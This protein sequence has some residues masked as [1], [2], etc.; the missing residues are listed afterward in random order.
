[1]KKAITILA[2]LAVIGVTFGSV[3]ARGIAPTS[4]TKSACSHGL[5]PGNISYMFWGAKVEDIEQT[6]SIAAAQKD[7]PGL[8]IK[9]IWDTGNYD[10]DLTTEL[11]SGNAPDVFQLDP[12]KRIKEF[13]TEGAALNLAPY[14]K[15]DHFNPKATYWKQC[16]VQAYYKG[17]GPY[18]LVRDCGN[19]SMV[20][21]NKNLFQARHVKFPTNSMTL[22]QFRADAV[23]LSGT[24]NYNGVSELRF[25]IG[26]QTDE[27]HINGYMFSF[28]GAWLTGSGKCGLT[29]KGSREG[30]QW[31]YNL[32]NKYHGA[33]TAGQATGPLGDFIGGF[34]HE[35][36]AMA[37]VG[38]W[39]LGYGV[40]PP[41]VT[42]NKPVSFKW[43]IALPAAGPLGH[44]GGMVDPALET[45]WSGSK[46]KH[47]AYEFTRFLTTSRPA[48]LEGADGIGIPGALKIAKSK[49]VQKE[50][51]P[52]YKTWTA[53]INDGLPLRTVAKHT[54]FTNAVLGDLGNFWNGSQSLNQATAKA[55]ADSKPY[56]G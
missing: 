30:L 1:M 12:G 19:A 8:H 37:L 52:Y 25:G 22:S 50:Y 2:A 46:H 5:V 49:V 21:F 7:C 10:V 45:V 28:G 16:I 27:Y 48:S 11:G 17:K 33:P 29:Q 20:I 53:G 13:V 3:Y 51:A 15:K 39:I 18:G 14:V 38:P 42:G 24:Y 55:C 34:E 32:A 31:W 56:L 43:G 23:K 44:N 26:I 41:A 40:K 35:R 47:A 4:V 9:G 54:Q 6:G 36:F